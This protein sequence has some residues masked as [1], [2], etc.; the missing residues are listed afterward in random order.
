LRAQAVD[1]SRIELSWTASS[2]ENVAGYWVYGDDGTVGTRFRRLGWAAGTT[3]TDVGL[4]SGFLYIYYVRAAV[5]TIE[6][7]ASNLAGDITRPRATPTPA[8]TPTPSPSPTSGPT[9]TA[10]P[11]P[12]ATRTSTPTTT[13]SPTPRQSPTPSVTP[14]PGRQLTFSVVSHRRYVDAFGELRIVGE[15]KN[16]FDV[17]AQAI[18]VTAILYDAQ[19][20]RLERATVPTLLKFV[21]AG[22]RVPFLIVR[23]VPEGFHSYTLSAVG[24]STMQSPSSSLA[25]VEKRQHEDQVGLYH[26]E[27]QVSNV[28][29]AAVDRVRVAVTIYDAD[30]DVVNAD[31]AY[32]TP[33]RLEPGETGTFHITVLEFPH[34]QRYTIQ[35]E[36]E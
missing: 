11:S 35:V 30:G 12:T 1:S 2:T 4:R 7:R 5:G 32:T 14:E 31:A 9:A 24:V 8:A 20:R 25:V 28:G 29:P 19:G 21:R 33:Q 23:P 6:S 34:A 26:V 36:G 3:F 15:V 16:D 18:M 22:H 17:N 27:G 13:P 10:L